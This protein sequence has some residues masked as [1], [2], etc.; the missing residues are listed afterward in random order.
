[1]KRITAKML[2]DAG[3]CNDRVVLFEREWPNGARVTLTN[4]RRATELGLSLSW[5]AHRLLPAP[6]SAAYRQAIAP[7]WAAYEQAEAPA[8]AVYEQAVASAWAAYE[9]AK[10]P[11][12][13]EAAKGRAATRKA[14]GKE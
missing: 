11:A 9:Q 7:A 10:V 3:A 14:T 5:A 12:F 1:M 6:A 8:W 4:C 13:Y 2:R